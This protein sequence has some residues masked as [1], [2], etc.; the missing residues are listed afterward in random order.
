M[1]DTTEPREQRRRRLSRKEQDEVWN[2][3]AE[4]YV[5]EQPGDATDL[6]KWS[7]GS[8]RAYFD[9]GTGIGVKLTCT[10]VEFSPGHSNMLKLCGDLAAELI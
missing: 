9:P 8:G 6:W 10:R 5:A 3:F 4:M 1:G 7:T 2:F